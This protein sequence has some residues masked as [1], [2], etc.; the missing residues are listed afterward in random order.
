MRGMEPAVATESPDAAPSTSGSAL[1]A[2][3]M[4]LAG[5]IVFLWFAPDSY[6]IY[7]AVHVTAI[8]IWV[9]GDVT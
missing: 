8:V 3:L 7:K 4:L 6:Q 1:L 9:G 2:G 5:T